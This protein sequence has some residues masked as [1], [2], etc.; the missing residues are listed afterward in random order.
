[1][2]VFRLMVQVGLGCLSISGSGC[3]CG[4]DNRFFGNDVSGGGPG[5][6]GCWQ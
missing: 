3:G 1:M 2:F 6:G 4:E 5:G